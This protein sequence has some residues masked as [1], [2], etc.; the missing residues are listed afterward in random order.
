LIYYDE[1]DEFLGADRKSL[2]LFGCKDIYEFK[3]KI[4][5]VSNFFIEREGYIY[6]FKNY[7]WLDFIN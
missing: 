2:D 1:Y 5:D 4:G 6:K 7:N 3:E